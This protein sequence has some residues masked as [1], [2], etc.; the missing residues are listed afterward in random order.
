MSKII[1]FGT[2]TGL[3]SLALQLIVRVPGHEGRVPLNVGEHDG[4]KFALLDQDRRPLALHCFATEYPWRHVSS[5]MKVENLDCWGIRLAPWSGQIYT[6]ARLDYKSP[7]GHHP[8]GHLSEAVCLR[9]PTL[10]RCPWESWPWNNVAK[11]AVQ[12]P[13]DRKTGS[14]SA[15][16]PVRRQFQA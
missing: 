5:V 4:S 3:C 9:L 2:L 7:Q 11:C 6:E 8:V 16:Y 13:T 1:R 10:L 15:P 14:V 12:R